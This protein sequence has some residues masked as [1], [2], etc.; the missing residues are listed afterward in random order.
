M[1]SIQVKYL[2]EE[3]ES[4]PVAGAASICSP[5]DLL[6]SD[7]VEI[8]HP[9]FPSGFT[10]VLLCINPLVCIPTILHSTHAVFK[11]VSSIS[12]HLPINFPNYHS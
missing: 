10:I 6:V 2:G 4:T 3:G 9:F 5:W 11:Y 1:L 7:S 8:L 12:V